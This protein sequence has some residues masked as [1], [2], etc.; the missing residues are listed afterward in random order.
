MQNRQ[1]YDKMTRDELMHL[2]IEK[3]EMINKCISSLKICEFEA[4]NKDDIMVIYKC[5]NNKALKI[6]KVMF[7][8]GYGNRIGKEYYTTRKYLEEFMDCM[9]GKEVFI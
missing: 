1:D 8:M 9:N 3:D 5:Q 2:C 4:L 6:L 7:Q